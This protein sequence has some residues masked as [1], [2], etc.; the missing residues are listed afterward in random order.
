MANPIVSFIYWVITSE[1]SH[2]ILTTWCENNT[3]INGRE[4]PTR[5]AI[6]E[7]RML[8]LTIYRVQEG[9]CSRC[10]FSSEIRPAR[11]EDLS[12]LTIESPRHS[13]SAAW[14]MGMCRLPPLCL[15][16]LQLH[17]KSSQRTTF[18]KNLERW[19]IFVSIMKADSKSFLLDC[20]CLF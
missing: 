3:G 1:T 10:V 2:N 13:L 9:P 14:D 12:D 16:S 11:W 7:A 19:G 6:W 4:K 8:L 5:S 17:F 18:Q 20:S 15:S